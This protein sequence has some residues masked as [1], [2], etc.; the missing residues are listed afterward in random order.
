MTIPKLVSRLKN[1]YSNSIEEPTPEEHH[2]FQKFMIKE[3]MKGWEC[4]FVPEDF[5][6][7]AVL[8]LVKSNDVI[9]DVGAGDLRFDLILSEKV[10]K[11]YAVEINPNI[12]ARAMRIID[13]D[14]P[15][16]LIV[17]RGNAFEFA[18]PPDV[19]LVLCLMMHNQHEYP[20]TWKDKRLLVGTHTG[21]KDVM[22]D[23]QFFDAQAS[24]IADLMEGEQ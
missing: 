18:L 22:M 24:G 16:N 7:S 23:E 12:L 15:K 19:T 11:I 2:A 14:M 4:F 17:I 13:L 3:G 5:F 8:K 6:Y 21:L 20:N 1:S 10:K 9:F